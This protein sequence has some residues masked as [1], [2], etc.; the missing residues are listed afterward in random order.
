MTSDKGLPFLDRI[1]ST[2]LVHYSLARNVLSYTKFYYRNLLQLWPLKLHSLYEFVS[3][4]ELEWLYSLDPHS[5][6]T[7]ILDNVTILLRIKHIYTIHK[8][9][10]FSIHNLKWNLRNHDHFHWNINFPSHSYNMSIHKIKH[11][12]HL[13]HNTIPSLYATQHA[14]VP[15]TIVLTCFTIFQ[16]LQPYSIQST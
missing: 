2:W 12:I 5:I 10:I 8:L 4:V 16:Y 15:Q 9:T 11:L 6:H 7:L 1:V 13:L 3:L 14:L